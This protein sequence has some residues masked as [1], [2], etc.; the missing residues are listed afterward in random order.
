MRDRDGKYE[1]EEAKAEIE[2]KEKKG[3]QK[4]FE[5]IMTEIFFFRMLKNPDFH[6]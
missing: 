1:K 3:R 6:I 2:W 5:E 4:A